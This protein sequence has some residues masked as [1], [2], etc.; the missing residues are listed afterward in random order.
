M[1]GVSES[2]V[3]QSLAAV[4]GDGDGV[5]VTICA[6]DFEI[7]VDLFVQPGA[8]ERADAIERGLAGENDRYVFSRDERST[9]ELVLDELRSRGLTVG[10]AESCTGGLVAARLTDVPGS[11]D[12]FRGAVVAYANEVKA[13]RAR[14]AGSGA[15]RAWRRLGADRGGDGARRSRG[16]RRRRRRLGHG[17]RRAGRRH[18]RR[19][20][21]DSSSCTPS[22]RTVSS[23]GASTSRATGRRSASARPSLR[24][25]SCA[26]LSRR[27]DRHGTHPA[28]AW[29]EMTGSGSSARCNCPTRPSQ[30]SLP[31]RRS[32]CP[33]VASSRPG[34]CTSRL[35]SSAHDRPSR[36]GDRR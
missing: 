21:S 36:A 18:S 15:G 6:R 29:P 32:T 17:C 12:V 8:E 9:A 31:G 13:A 23:A 1:F 30:T 35:R 33:A 4:G 34:T 10:T 16:A 22:G 27:R 2:A 20:R 26:D 19:S 28:L 25:T 24:C 14:R 5:D 3:A 11:S 7:H